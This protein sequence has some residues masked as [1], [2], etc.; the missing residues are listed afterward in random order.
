M[1]AQDIESF[2]G[3]QVETDATLVAID[4]DVDGAIAVRQDWRHAAGDVAIA[5][6]DLDDLR[7]AVSQVHRSYGRGYPLA[8]LDDAVAF[9]RSDAHVWAATGWDAF[10]TSS[11]ISPVCSPAGETGRTE[12]GVREN[13]QG[14]LAA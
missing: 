4:R 2:G 10:M 14:R 12:A 13:V 9:D 5:G 6:L 8:Q 1:R 11:R 3:R 7:A